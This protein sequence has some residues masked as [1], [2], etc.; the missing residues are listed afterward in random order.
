MSAVSKAKEY[1]SLAPF[2]DRL[3]DNVDYD[4]VHR[5]YLW[6]FETY[7]PSPRILL[8]LACGTGTLSFAFEK[9]GIDVIGVDS[10]EQMLSV[11][12]D[13]KYDSGSQV[14]FL[15]QEAQKLDLYGTVD[16]TVCNLDAV[17][18]FPPKVLPEIIRRISLFTEPGGLF[19]FDVNSRYKF[20]QLLNDCCY[21]YDDGDVFC[22]WSGRYDGRKKAEICLD[23]FERTQDGTY[24]RET[25]Q[26]DEFY[27]DDKYLCRLLDENGFDLLS[28]LSDYTDKPPEETSQRIHYLARKRGTE[29]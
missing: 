4:S 27:Y 8:D 21:S 20:E 10:S 23:I 16:V 3:T 19:V 2:Y 24:T 6:V 9:D 17:N 13:K 15:K 7:H 26:I 18:H 12:M 5:F 1:R 25:Q 29:T 22:S 11:A 14:L 28:C